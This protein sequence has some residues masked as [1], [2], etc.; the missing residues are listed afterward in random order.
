MLGKALSIKESCCACQILDNVKIH[1][2][3]KFNQNILCVLKVISIYTNGMDRCMDGQTHSMIIVH[4]FRSCIYTP[5][6]PSV[7]P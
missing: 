1:T 6:A 7:G 4:N 5:L 2:Y 3:A